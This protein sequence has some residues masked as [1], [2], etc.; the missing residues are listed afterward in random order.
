MY[1]TINVAHQGSIFKR[2]PKMCILDCVTHGGARKDLGKCPN[3]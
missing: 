1:A 2:K 3:N